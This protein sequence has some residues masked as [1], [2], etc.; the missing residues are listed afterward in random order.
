MNEGEF[1]CVNNES[2]DN[3][4]NWITNISIVTSKDTAML[5]YIDSLIDYDCIFQDADGNVSSFI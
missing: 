5:G 2:V 3:T 1:T 4:S